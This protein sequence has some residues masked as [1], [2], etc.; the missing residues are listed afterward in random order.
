[1]RTVISIERADGT[2]DNPKMIMIVQ[3]YIIALKVLIS[4]AFII[5]WETAEFLNYFGQENGS[6]HKNIF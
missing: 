2:T 6:L 1:M 5:I 4:S 3:M